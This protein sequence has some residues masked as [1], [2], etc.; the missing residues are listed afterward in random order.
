MGG[1]LQAAGDPARAIETVA[2]VLIAGG[3][4]IFIG[5]MLLLARA[6]RRRAGT[7]RTRLWIVGGGLVF[8]GVVLAGLFAWT[9]AMTPA[10]KPVPPP[11]ALVV[12]V[13]GTLWWWDVRYRDPA[14]GA[15]I[16]TA[17]EVRIPTGRPVYLA[18]DSADVIHSFWVPQLAGKMDMVPGRLQHLL[19]SAGRPGVY[20]GQCAEFC[21]EQHARM[22]LHVVALAPAEFDAWLAAQARPAL[23]PATP[24]QEAGRQAFLAQRCDACHAVRGVGGDSRLGPDLTHVGSRLHLAA[25]T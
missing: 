11:G 8:P 2:W 1:V 13:T 16:R 24:R 3:L 25:G 20:R 10:W 23:P 17:N 15:E 18:L 6:L 22:A 21:G 12:A 14:T 19:L 4:A 9:L 5:V 7:V